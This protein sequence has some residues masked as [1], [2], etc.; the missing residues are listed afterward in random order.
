[1]VGDTP[2]DIACA[3]ADG[4]RCVAVATGPYGVDELSAADAVASDA[5]EL[6]AALQAFQPLTS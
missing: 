4:L 1:M 6:L 5:R 3:H 2:R